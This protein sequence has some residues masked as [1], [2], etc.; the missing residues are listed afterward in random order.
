[1]QSKVGAFLNGGVSL[2]VGGPLAVAC[3]R[4]N[5]MRVGLRV[6]IEVLRKGSQRDRYMQGACSRENMGAGGWRQKRADESRERETRAHR[7]DT[8]WLA[9]TACGKGRRQRPDGVW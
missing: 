1:M 6:P 8:S 7:C 3:V 2:K 9:H 4:P 5:G